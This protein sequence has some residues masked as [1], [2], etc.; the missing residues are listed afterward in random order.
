MDEVW[1]LVNFS[2]YCHK[3]CSILQQKQ[4]SKSPILCHHTYVT[5]AVFGVNLFELQNY[6][7]LNICLHHIFVGRTIQIIV[8]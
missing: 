4:F 1:P 3:K 5:N 8:C 6:W 7:T 2:E